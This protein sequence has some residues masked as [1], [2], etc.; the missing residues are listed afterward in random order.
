[1]PHKHAHQH[2]SPGLFSFTPQEQRA[3]IDNISV[4]AN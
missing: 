1:V 3:Y 2:G 4:T